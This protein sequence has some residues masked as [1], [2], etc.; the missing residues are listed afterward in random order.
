MKLVCDRC[1][2]KSRWLWPSTSTT[3]SSSTDTSPTCASTSSSPHTI[4]SS[5][6]STRRVLS[7]QNRKVHI[8]LECHSVCPLVKIGTPHTFWKHSPAV[9]VVGGPNSDDWRKRLGL[10]LLCG[11][12]N[13]ADQWEMVSLIFQPMRVKIR[14][15]P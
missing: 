5:S 3:R 12:T 14:H 7:G 6:I 8:Y 13:P 2:W 11:Q 4:R 9:E 10:C 1:R 15:P